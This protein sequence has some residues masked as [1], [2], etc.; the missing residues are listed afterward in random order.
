[1]KQFEV[2]QATVQKKHVMCPCC[3]V[4]QASVDDIGPGTYEC[5]N[6]WNP[7]LVTADSLAVDNKV[8]IVSTLEDLLKRIKKLEKE[9]GIK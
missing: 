8:E 3:D 1:M 7:F 2:K 9:L 5:E 4:I 6:C